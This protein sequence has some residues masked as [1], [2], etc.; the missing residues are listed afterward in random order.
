MGL[1]VPALAV[2]AGTFV[3][4][5]ARQ[6]SGRGPRPWMA[7]GV[8]GLAMI[9]VGG[10]SPFG[11][12]QVLL[13]N[14]PIF[15]L[16]AALFVFVAALD[17]N[18]S[19]EHL[20]RWIVGRA[21]RIEDLPFLLFV[22]FGLVSA[23]LVND[24]LVLVGVPVILA[25][26]RRQGIPPVPLLLVLAYAVT[27]GSVLTPFA[28]P[29]NLLVALDSG[30]PQPITTFLRYL[31]L[32]T[33]ASLLL[34]GLYLRWAMRRELRPSGTPVAPVPRVPLFPSGDWAA[35][36]RRAP[37]VV[38]FPAVLIA[39]VGSELLTGLTGVPSVPIQ[40]V[41]L[42]GA[43]IVLVVSS[44]RV[45]IVRRVDWTI[46]L[47]FAGLFVV[48]AGGVAGGLLGGLSAVL[49]IAG[50]G[51]ASLPGLGSV[52]L[53]SLLGPQLVSNVPFVAIE[54][55]LLHGLGYG[56]GS[57]T[58]WLALAGA[59]TLAGNITLLG[60]ASNLIL[61]ER[62]ESLGVRVRLASFVRYGLPL[63]AIAATLLFVCLWLGA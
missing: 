37:S 26:A 24:A 35:R 50:P 34:G 62:A 47:L 14:G 18:G 6:L 10:L 16:L 31:L 46:L 40:D 52:T 60:A 51:A 12:V 43:A 19:F 5:I 23:L 44:A 8:G 4:L 59:T 56:A 22:G 45:R 29:Q 3:A 1:Y 41:A 63:T 25:V 42:A 32:P 13:S 55:P 53:A 39:L 27:V 9:A 30:M 49:P 17:L 58:T 2:F 15:L 48:V 21:R 33:V 11:A 38:V 28:N 36:I 61:V 54:I 57:T 7:L 20:A